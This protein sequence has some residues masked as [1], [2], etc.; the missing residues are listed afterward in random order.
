MPTTLT[1]DA[2]V[3][4]LL[5]NPVWLDEFDWRAVEASRRYSIAGVPINDRGVKQGGQPMTLEAGMTLATLQT[6]YTW[7]ALPDQAFTLGYRG[8]TYDVTF[9]HTA[10]P[11]QAAP[12]WPVADPAAGDLY[13]ATLRF[14]LS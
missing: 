4:T 14:I 11:V 2:D 12:L 8:T 5:G 3:A 9:D 13:T 6:L 1:K 10:Q 7:A